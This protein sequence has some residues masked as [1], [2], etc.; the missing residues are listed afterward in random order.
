MASVGFFF[1]L[2]HATIVFMLA[3]PFAIGV[4]ALRRPRRSDSAPSSHDR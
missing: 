1:S 4:K 3:F 2:G